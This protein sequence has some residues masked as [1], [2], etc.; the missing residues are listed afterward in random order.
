[1][2]RSIV[3]EGRA[4]SFCGR[5]ATWYDGGAAPIAICPTCLRTRASVATRNYR[6]REFA[7]G[8]HVLAGR[9]IVDCVF[10]EWEAVQGYG[11]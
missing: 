9:H 1:V 11:R 8:S 3:I 5:A 10:C 2:T 4:C 6:L 7:H